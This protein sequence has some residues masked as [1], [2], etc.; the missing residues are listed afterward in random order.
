MARNVE[1][2]ARV[3]DPR[4]VRRR[5]LELADERPRVLEQVDTF[6]D[7]KRG[8]LKLRELGEGRRATQAGIVRRQW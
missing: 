2:K 3:D 1:I 4:A 8:R 7:V 6:Y 5:A